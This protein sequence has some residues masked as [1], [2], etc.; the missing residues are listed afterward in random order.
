MPKKKFIFASLLL[1]LIA[2]VPAQINFAQSDAVTL[3]K[4]MSGFEVSKLQK[5]LKTLG[6]F[7]V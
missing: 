5:D 7:S 4:G 3:K 1:L 2:L 6:F